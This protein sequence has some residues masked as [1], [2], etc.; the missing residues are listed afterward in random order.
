MSDDV[1]HGGKGI[2]SSALLVAAVATILVAAFVLRVDAPDRASRAAEPV[3]VPPASLPL[4]STV[5]PETK[6]SAAPAHAAP[7]PGP[8]EQGKLAIPAELRLATRAEHDRQRVARARGRWTAQLVVACKFE[9]VDRLLAASG[10]STKIYLLPAQL[11][12]ASCFRVCF[13]AYATSKEAA[14]AADLPKSLRGD[15]K[16][17]AVEFAKVAP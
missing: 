9:T 12:G 7:A 2:L 10:G 14:A 17:R 8:V 15:E 16:V 3:A 11:N 4:G 13:G 5:S 6:D 1:D